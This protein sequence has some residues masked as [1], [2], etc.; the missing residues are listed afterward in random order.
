MTTQTRIEMSDIKVVVGGRLVD[1]TGA[2]P[3]DD[4][5]VVIEGKRIKAVGKEGEV[6]VPAGAEVIDASGKTVM[7]G[8]IE[9]H[10]HPVRVPQVET[11]RYPFSLSSSP[12]MALFGA[13]QIFRNFLEFGITTVRILHPAIPNA[14]ELR[15]EWLVALRTAAELGLIPGPRVVAAGVV[16]PTGGHFQA[17]VP[18]RI[19]P[20][21]WWGADGVEEVRKQTRLCAYENVDLIKVLG[22][23]GGGGMGLDAPKK[24]G[25]SLDEMKIVVDEA[26]FKGLPVSVHAH[27][28][29]GFDVAAE[30]LGKGDSMEHC[31]YL[32]EHD[33]AVKKMS[34][35]GIWMVPTW[36]FRLRRIN[37]ES[38]PKKKSEY[39]KMLNET[40]VASLHKARKAGVKIAVGTDNSPSDWS[41][42]GVELHG[43]V[44]YGGIPPLEA[45]T[46]ATKNGAEC[47]ALEDVGTIKEGKIAD[48]IVVDG[49][50]LKDITV[51]QEKK[52]I[53]TVIK[54]GCVVSRK[55]NL[56]W[57]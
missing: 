39:E 15:G 6:D 42:I 29:P 51:L 57:N 5:V 50:P 40:L 22:T 20:P 21:G 3:L 17:M 14:P 47:L 10:T 44:K 43:Y 36:T 13:A 12:V 1:G 35:K 2:E 23:T 37:A 26:R 16:L 4:S 24:Q 52:K 11:R 31:S 28:G 33:E 27:G 38:D 48:L 56:I 25:Y 41:S 55:G 34:E 49:N 19:M 7:P 30:A 53:D 8:L 45:I 18:P 32:Y 54:E 9:A 46:W